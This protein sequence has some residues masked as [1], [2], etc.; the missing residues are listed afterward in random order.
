MSEKLKTCIKSAGDYLIF[1]KTIQKLE[2][3]TDKGSRGIDYFDDF[4]YQTEVRYRQLGQ[5]IRSHRRKMV[6]RMLQV[7]PKLFWGFDR[8][9]FVNKAVFAGLKDVGGRVG[10]E[11]SEKMFLN[12]SERF[13]D[14]QIELNPRSKNYFFILIFCLIILKN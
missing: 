6:D 2:T 12:F 9:I 8:K 7:V 13:F 3:L 4:V 10:V 1:P 11:V 14:G 5:A